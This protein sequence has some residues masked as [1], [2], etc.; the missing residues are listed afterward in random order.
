M[1]LIFLLCPLIF[2]YIWIMGKKKMSED[3][4]EDANF[5]FSC[6][7]IDFLSSHDQVVLQI[8]SQEFLL[9]QM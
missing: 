8:E 7:N 6:Y 3:H 1:L 9:T 4:L 5:L 2:V